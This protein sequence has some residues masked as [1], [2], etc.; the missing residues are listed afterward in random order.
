[1]RTYNMEGVSMRRRGNGFLSLE[2]LGL[3]EKRPSLISGDY[4]VA[5]HAGSNDRPYQ[6]SAFFFGLQISVG[7]SYKKKFSFN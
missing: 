3:A 4:I 5:R 2:V 7:H 1:M 6:V